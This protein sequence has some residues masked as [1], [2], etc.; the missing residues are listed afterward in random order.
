MKSERQ[1]T[2]EQK[3]AI[4]REHLEEK[5]SVEFLCEKYH[6]RPEQ[7]LRWKK[8]LFDNAVRFF[9]AQ[10]GEED[11]EEKVNRLTTQIKQ[12]NQLID[13]LRQENRELKK[14]SA[15]PPKKSPGR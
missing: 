4:I 15:T 3:A 12:R 10:S 7:F 6:I 9:A 13:E 14:L 11:L 2:P 1:F 5:R 8:E